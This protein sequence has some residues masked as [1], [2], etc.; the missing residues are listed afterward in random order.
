MARDHS[1]HH[2][3]HSEKVPPG[4]RV[5]RRASIGEIHFANGNS[6]RRVTVPPELDAARVIR[7]LALPPAKS[8]LLL[9][10]GA[11][12]MDPALGERLQ[13]LFGRGLVPAA[14]EC[15]ALILD[16]GT[17]TG[18]MALIGKGVAERGHPP[19]LIGVAPTGR[20]TFPGDTSSGPDGPRTG[21]DPNHSHFVLV[22]GEDWGS[23]TSML[24]RLV[25]ALGADIPV[26]VV[27]VNGGAL[28]KDEVFRAVR[29]AMMGSRPTL[30]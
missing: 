14:A 10:G 1:A 19:P 9:I 24:C 15:G 21:L 28:T 5:R 7:A 23:E 20:V 16:G 17:Q 26:L 4:A 27:L 25:A 22:H 13:Q 11:D 2:P 18:I 12:E 3:G 30:I 8:L 6:A 29:R